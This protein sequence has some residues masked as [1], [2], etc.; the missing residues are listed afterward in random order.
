[1]TVVASLSR[2]LEIRRF[3]PRLSLGQ[4]SQ[5]LEIARGAASVESGRAGEFVEEAIQNIEAQ[6]A[7]PVGPQ[8]GPVRSPQLSFLTALRVLR[9]L[10]YQSWLLRLDDEGIYLVPPTTGATAGA[11]AKDTLRQSFE[12]ARS[13][14]FAEAPIAR[15]IRDMERKGIAQLFADGNELA[16]R[17][18][19]AVATGR[20]DDAIDPILQPAV[21]GQKDEVTGLDLMDVW[22]YAR[23]F[24]SIPYNSTPG[25]NMFYLV[26]DAASGTRPLIGIAGLGNPV[27]GLAK[28][29]ESLGWSATALEKRWKGASADDRRELATRLVNT[30]ETAIERVYTRDLPG[31][32]DDHL[33]RLR[34]IER[35]AAVERLREIDGAG[36]ERSSEYRLIRDA[37]K[38]VDD[39]HG[40]SV[41]WTAVAQTSLYRRKRASTLADLV[42][43]LSTL[44]DGGLPEH[45]DRLAQLKDDEGLK[46]AVETALRTIKQTVMAESVME[47]TTC[48]ALPPY[49]DVLGGKLVAMLM[50]SPRVVADYRERYAGRISLIASAIEGRPVHR[51]TKLAILTTASLYPV[52]SSQYN[53][54]RIPGSILGGSGDVRYDTL[55]R[56]E[57][58]GTV[59]FAPDTVLSLRALLAASDSTTRISH[60]FGEGAS[61]K[62]RAIRGGLDELGLSSNTFMRH[63]SPRIL[64][65]V[66]LCRNAEEVLLGLDVE[67]DYILGP[68]ADGGVAAIAAHW[69]TRWLH[70]RAE[71]AETLQALRTRSR[72]SFLLQRELREQRKPTPAARAADGE[73][74]IPAAGEGIAFIERLYRSRNS[75]ADRLSAAQL[76]SVHVDLGVDGYLLDRAKAGKQ[77]VITGNPGDGKTH[78]IQRLR[79]AL[80]LIGAKVITDA[81]AEED[82]EILS[83]WRSCAERQTPFVLAVNEWPLFV[84]ER[85]ARARSFPNVTEAIRQVRQ[86]TY[87]LSEPPPPPALGVVTI[88]LSL[89]NLL[90]ADTVRQV[91][92]RLSQET[93]YSDTHNADPAAANADSLRDPRIQ[94]RIASLLNLVSRRVT[95]VTMRQLVGLVSYL[96]AGGTSSSERLAAQGTPQFHYS[97]LAF[98]EGEGPLFDAL[99]ALDPVALTDPRHDNALWNG[100]ALGGWISEGTTLPAPIQV[101]DADRTEAFAALKRRFYFEHDSGSTLLDLVPADESLFE[102]LLHEGVET[103]HSLVREMVLAIN[104][105]YEPDCPP[106]ERDELTLWQSHRFDV[107]APETFVSSSRFGSKDLKIANPKHASWVDEWLPQSQ[108]NPRTFALVADAGSSRERAL[109]V[110]DRLLFL[111]LKDAERGLGRAT[112]SRTATRR[113]TRFVDRLSGIS[114]G[115]NPVEDIRVRNIKTGLDRRFEIQRNPAR[116]VL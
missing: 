58:F 114:V 108:R 33:A 39:G 12:F 103:P 110:V 45:S 14:Q 9:D 67:P 63:H 71:R 17:L 66:R 1:L 7:P 104:R 15:F 5:L 31:A 91:I 28:R 68:S 77:V 90:A 106:S 24:W 83:S 94:L 102:R 65:G 46:R 50:A 82:D 111:T 79:P 60:L 73:P 53:R 109:L 42:R 35:E 85:K 43:A 88:D 107:R 57:S 8:R 80:E 25:R 95:H 49:R 56:S 115:V 36:Q 6:V 44:R 59:H 11:H 34:E 51:E 20:F 48:G 40:E 52:G 99:R 61:P 64:Y 76:G 3:R 86:G 81:N 32:D 75:F 27:L 78:L 16:S 22:R 37:Q 18:A 72:E 92:D 97:N 105:F 38:A 96:I 101:A 84:L 112:W 87:Y 100:T 116:Y 62:M 21:A 13:A 98:E 2:G 19:H 4:H 69:R 29:D 113:L 26:R 89:R 47:I 74:P 30:L 93:F 41:D 10:A 55:G 70:P 23:Y 54:V